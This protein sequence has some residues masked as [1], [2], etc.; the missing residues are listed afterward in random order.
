[1]ITEQQQSL[2]DLKK[3]GSHLREGS[4]KTLQAAEETPAED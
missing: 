4:R 3:Q 1:V 2:E